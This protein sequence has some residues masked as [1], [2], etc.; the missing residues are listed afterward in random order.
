MVVLRVSV[1]ESDRLGI[2]V[3]DPNAV[4][5]A[6][7]HDSLVLLIFENESISTGFV[8]AIRV[9]NETTPRQETIPVFYFEITPKQI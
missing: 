9:S 4:R 3:V 2:D 7:V 8:S 1:S 6:E 5:K